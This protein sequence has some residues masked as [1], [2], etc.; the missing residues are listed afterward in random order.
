[1]QWLNAAL[2][3]SITM[4]ILSMVV[5]TLVETLHRLLRLRADGLETMLRQLFKEVI[6]PHLDTANTHLGQACDEFIADMMR[7]RAEPQTRVARLLHSQC[8]QKLDVEKFM[9]RLGASAHGDALRAAM[10]RVEGS[11]ADDVLHDVAQQFEAFGQE[12]S[13]HFQRRARLVS[14]IVALALAWYA[15][16]NP[17]VL[18]KTYLTD[19][20]TTEHII[21]LEKTV[22]QRYLQLTSQVTDTPGTDGS[23]APTPSAQ[24]TPAALKANLDAASQ[25]IRQLRD[26]GAPLGWTAA[27]LQEADFGTSRFLNLPLPG[28]IGPAAL[29]TVAWLL[30]GGLLIGLGGP[31]WFD[32]VRSF[33]SLRGAAGGKLASSEGDAGE[34]EKPTAIAVAK[35]KTAANGRDARIGQGVFA[36]DGDDVAVG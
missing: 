4:L 16:V 12:A 27:R 26:L 19:E 14:V 32:A 29:S 6:A 28:K 31:F 25:D 1:M 10:Q 22:E 30:V 20:K 21:A 17:Y 9:S 13:E 35:F 24:T 34:L 3:F 36:A 18:L 15:N 7:N 11:V 5:S 23:A 8:L 33:S 2:A